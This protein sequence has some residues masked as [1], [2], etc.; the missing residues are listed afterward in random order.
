KE[1]N[2]VVRIKNVSSATFGQAAGVLRGRGGTNVLEQTGIHPESYTALREMAQE[3][4]A[5]PS[6]LIGEGAKKIIPL[7]QKWAEL[8]GEFT[9]N[10][11]LKELEAP[12]RDPRDL[13]KVFS[14]RDDIFEMKD[15]KEQMICPGIV[16]NVTNFGAFVDIGVHQDGLVHISELSHQFV[17]DPRKVVSPGDQVQAKILAV[18]LDKN[19]IS[20][21]LKLEEKPKVEFKPKPKH[22]GPRPERQ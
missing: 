18:D 5:T 10:D 16:T 13:F 19:Q 21:T 6:T 11:I 20:L 3:V 17:D 9:F 2:G 22:D 4:Q 8:I 14:F 1:R 12:G 15:L 7:K